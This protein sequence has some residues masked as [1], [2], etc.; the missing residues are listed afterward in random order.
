[1]T[2]DNTTGFIG[3]PGTGESWLPL[4]LGLSVVPA[5]LGGSLS[6]AESVLLAQAVA[7]TAGRPTLSDIVRSLEAQA[8]RNAGGTVPLNET[9]V[10]AGDLARRL[11][12]VIAATPRRVL[13][14]EVGH[15]SGP[16]SSPRLDPLLEHR[17][18]S[19]VS[20]RAE[21]GPGD[22]AR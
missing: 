12:A 3:E 13:D 8:D 11:R 20:E 22:C 19:D 16:A 14:D 5:L 2:T 4:T 17:E 15:I 21:P 10:L 7:E 9:A 18:R 1:M 6:D